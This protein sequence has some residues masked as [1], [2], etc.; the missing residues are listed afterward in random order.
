MVRRDLGKEATLIWRGPPSRVKTG[1]WNSPPSVVMS[2][3]ALNGFPL[4]SGSIQYSPSPV[5]SPILAMCW[6]DLAALVD[7]E[8]N[9][10][11]SKNRLL[12]WRDQGWRS[13]ENTPL[14]SFWPGFNP[15]GRYMWVEFVVGSRPMLREVF[16]RVLPFTTVLINQHLQ[17][18]F[19]YLLDCA[20]ICN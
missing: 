4:P 20:G 12:L 18:P 11:K 19:F 10:A 7:T 8:P 2:Q 3:N 13:S 5:E 17:I 14:P 16:A 15:P 9:K 6:Q 1:N